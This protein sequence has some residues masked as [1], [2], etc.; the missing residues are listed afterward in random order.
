M[1]SLDAQPHCWFCHVAAHLLLLPFLDELI[2][3]ELVQMSDYG[4]SDIRLASFT[5]PVL[6]FLYP[7]R[8]IWPCYT[9]GLRELMLSDKTVA[10]PLSVSRNDVNQF[11]LAVQF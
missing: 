8:T 6:E 7:Y 10:Y 4:N 1:S 9:S 11:S 5:T 2:E 3:V